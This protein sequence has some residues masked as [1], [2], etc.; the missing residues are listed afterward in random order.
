MIFDQPA[1]RKRIKLL[2]E[3]YILDIGGEGRHPA[4]WNLNPRNARTIGPHRGEPIPRL[5]QGRGD[6]I[7]LPDQSVDIV[8]AERVP[9]LVTTLTEIHRVAKPGASI[10][11]RH[12]RV[13]WFD[14]H[15]FAYQHLPGRRDCRMIQ[16][17]IQT[18]QETT[19]EFQ[20][21]L[22]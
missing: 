6:K 22:S 18:L 19:I 3:P 15:R 7:P 12:A 11:L 8:I 21:I 17:G 20:P 13:P 10:I 4:A 16:I 2:N 1:S 14:P 5:I 9:L